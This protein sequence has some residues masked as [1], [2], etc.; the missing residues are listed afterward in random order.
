MEFVKFLVWEG[1]KLV[2]EYPESGP[3]ILHSVF[4]ISAGYP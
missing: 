3:Q 4:E 1:V 2:G